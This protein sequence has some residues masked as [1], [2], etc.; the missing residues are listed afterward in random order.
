MVTTTATR[1]GRQNVRGR[2]RCR[3]TS[4]IVASRPNCLRGRAWGTLTGTTNTSECERGAA[5]RSL[6]EPSMRFTSKPISSSL[7]SYSD[8]RIAERRA[9]CPAPLVRAPRRD[10][11]MPYSRRTSTCMTCGRSVGL[12]CSDEAAKL[13]CESVSRNLAGSSSFCSVS[14]CKTSH[15]SFQARRHSTAPRWIASSGFAHKARKRLFIAGDL[16]ILA[17]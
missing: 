11:I 3:S 12:N 6:K 16:Y 15:S 14:S 10:T 9:V 1:R 7:L 13:R 5:R 2:P 4:P 17:G 8:A